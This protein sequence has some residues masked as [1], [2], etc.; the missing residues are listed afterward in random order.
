MRVDTVR[1]DQN[2]GGM[3]RRKLDGLDLP[4]QSVVFPDHSGVDEGDI[5]YLNLL[6]PLKMEM[7]EHVELKQ[8]HLIDF[9]GQVRTTLMCAIL[10]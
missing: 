2:W 10:H 1:V 5:V 6:V 7:A 8:M 4:A 3:S 9:V